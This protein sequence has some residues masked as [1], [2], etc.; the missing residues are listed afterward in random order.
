M[1][2]R[3]YL[4]P[5]PPL[6]GPAS[7]EFPCC[8]GRDTDDGNTWLQFQSEGAGPRRRW[9]LVSSAHS[10]TRSLLGASFPKRR[11]NAAHSKT[12][13]LR[14]L[15]KKQNKKTGGC[16]NC[17]RPSRIFQNVPSPLNPVLWY[18]RLGRPLRKR[19][20]A[21]LLALSLGGQTHRGALAKMQILIQRVKRRA[22]GGAFSRSSQAGPATKLAGPR[23]QA[24]CKAPCLKHKNF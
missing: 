10:T 14:L 3:M 4:P 12:L 24:K 9:V 7:E 2:P 23:A 18:H 6:H 19:C 5:P 11:G 20:R 17:R 21:G 16:Q 15:K 1:N 22:R 8:L 13:S